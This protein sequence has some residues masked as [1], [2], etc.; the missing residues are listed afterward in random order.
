MSGSRP[1]RPRKLSRLYP[2]AL[3]VFAG[4]VGGA[5][6]INNNHSVGNTLRVYRI[7]VAA[8]GEFTQ[9]HGGTK[10][11]ALA[12]IKAIVAK[13][14]A[15]Y[16]PE[17]AIRFQLI[18]DAEQNKIIYTNEKTDPYSAG[19]RAAQID[20]NQANL[21]A[22]IGSANY[23]IGHVFGRMA[24]GSG[25]LAGSGVGK[26]GSKARGVT[27]TISPS[28]ANE[29]FLSVVI[30]EIGHQFGAS[31]TFNSN[32]AG[33]CASNRMATN[34]YEPGSGTTIMSYAGIC[35]THDL[36]SVQDLYFHASSFEQINQ[37]IADHAYAAPYDTVNTGNKIPT[38]DAGS[39]YVIPAN[40]P[41]E[42]TATG[43]DA[44]GDPLTYTWEQLDL[45][46]AWGLP[47]SDDGNRPLFRSFKPSP[48]PTRTFPRLSNLLA[49]TIDPGELLPTTNRE[50][51]FRVTVRDG[52]P[53]G[54]GVHSSD[55]A[56]QVVDTGTAF[57]VTSP[58]GGQSWTGGASRTV[59]WRVA[60]TAGNGIN[61][62]HVNILLSTDGGQSF[63]FLLATTANDGSASIS[64]P[65]ITTSR[66]RIKVQ[67]ASN[68]FFDIS[69]NDFAITA[70]S[71]ATGVTFTQSGGDTTATEDGI[72]DSYEIH[73]N[74]NPGGSV[75]VIATADSQSEI[76][77]DGNSFAKAVPLVFNS[78]AAKTVYI[79]AIDDGELEGTHPSR[80]SH[81]ISTSSSN[82]YK[83]SLVINQLEARILDNDA[84][85]VIGVDFNYA[86]SDPSPENWK[87]LVLNSVST[88][89]SDLPFDDGTP[90]PIDLTLQ[91][92]TSGGLSFRYSTA[93]ADSSSKPQHHPNLDEID[94]FN[95]GTAELTATWRDLV[96]G[97]T[98]GV[99]V[100][101]LDGSADEYH[102]QSV[103]I[104]G[105][106]TLPSFTQNLVK[107]QLQINDSVGS[108]NQS[109]ASYEQ[110]VPANAD[111]EITI[112]IAPMANTDIGLAG[113]ALREILPTE[114]GITL[115]QATVAEGGDSDTYQFNLNSAPSGTMVIDI[116]ADAD[117]EISLDGINFAPCQT[118]TVNTTRPVIVTV[119]AIDDT[120]IEGNHAS[121][122]THTIISSTSTSYPVGMALETSL[123][124][125]TDNDSFSPLLG[126]DF[127]EQE[128][129]T[130]AN[131][132]LMTRNDFFGVQDLKWENGSS[133]N[134]DFVSTVFGYSYGPTV[135]LSSTIP[136]HSPAIDKIDYTLLVSEF[137]SPVTYT[138][139]DLAPNRV[140]NVYVFAAENFS[141]PYEI[142]QTVTL[143]GQGNPIEFTQ[144][145]TLNRELWI[146]GQRG[147]SDLPL[148][149]YAV[150]ISSN[151]SGEIA[152]TLASNGV[153]AIVM[154]G[155]A[156]Q[157]AP[158]LSGITVD[159]RNG[160][161]VGE[162]GGTDSYTIALQAAP[163]G[164]VE[165]TVSADAQSEVSLDG[166]NFAST[167]KFTRSNT[168]PMTIVVRAIDDVNAEA[169][170]HTSR[171]SHA[172]TASGDTARYPTST[173]IPK[174]YAVIE[175]ND[176]AQA[177][178]VS[179]A[180]TD[181]KGHEPSDDAEF[182][183]S[184]TSGHSA[185]AGGVT[186][187]F[188][189][190]GTA[191]EG[192]D[193]AAI[194]A[195]A[196]IA[197]GSNATT[198]PID[199]IN[200]SDTELPESVILTLTSTSVGNI[201]IAESSKSAKII[202]TSDDQTVY[203]QFLTAA[204]SE[205]DL[206]DPAKE[207]TL[208]GPEVDLDQ[209]GLA[210]IQEYFHN[211]S[212]TTP[213]N[214]PISSSTVSEGG[215]QYLD[216]VFPRRKDY[217][218]VEFCIQGATSLTEDSWQIYTGAVETVTPLDAEIDQ[219][220][221]RFDIT[222]DTR[223]FWRLCLN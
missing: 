8:T 46:G 52:V 1:T 5:A 4:V 6:F 195:S 115:T 44:D 59:E 171:I 192:S 85:R 202:I 167:G 114:P 17:L 48:N 189:V 210:T 123:V 61:A 2:L 215:K 3:A 62:S 193:Y 141:A 125:I 113:L 94:G 198:V 68:I 9:Y 131:W 147:S 50:L 120:A 218:G 168:D 117:S 24:I 121:S 72:I 118:V 95:S 39:D 124:S 104:R 109:L 142:D 105:S 219:V 107:D 181:A 162:S 78:T 32:S 155:F 92:D 20:Q 176:S 199:I 56:L 42:L 182:K 164:P 73:L 34:A 119:R 93:P 60:G 154:S 29:G 99:Y 145:S 36:Q 15:V 86:L 71:A 54:G 45:G 190:G 33:T 58:N 133:S 158:V 157:E 172:I 111:G 216:I 163:D 184:L 217:T 175:E 173:V 30:H 96:P 12:A 185:P 212:L 140:Y 47:L 23:D 161:A 149:S 146:N 80:I 180:A 204:F 87:S 116:G 194:G 19:D 27:E 64:L 51:N 14:N 37:Y 223:Q 101:G 203:Q 126:L 170:K 196:V 75:T 220:R 165:I 110:T 83:S 7:A 222:G 98:Y 67:G 179:I 22:V 53:G 197:A 169:A 151:A 122:I 35:G 89:V 134:I 178:K 205:E 81:H 63:P 43:A 100:L 88:S 130:P 152:M 144:K 21:D 65:N 57:A 25:G 174:V 28:A 200:D 166:K 79:Q 11:G 16:E 76:S 132:N 159:I 106:T 41:F 148:E 18:S 69:N 102:G 201:T 209:D 129:N 139:K 31:H 40:T 213:N 10:A 135:P 112:E 26:S 221:F 177:S 103:T 38:V 13:I 150:P 49:N 187:H 55:V 77:T 108:Q 91:Y 191:T 90:S 208:W 207:D 206:V 137:L 153:P 136:I 214:D 160:L 127:D 156:L 128:A 183:I 74:T 138:W 97:R 143:T 82:T 66:A 186:V 188:T 70:N 84:P 211:L